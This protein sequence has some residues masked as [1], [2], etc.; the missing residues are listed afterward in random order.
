MVTF[1]MIVDKYDGFY[2]LEFI[3][4]HVVD[5]LKYSYSLHIEIFNALCIWFLHFKK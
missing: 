2:N 3:E 4:S 5:N 1:A